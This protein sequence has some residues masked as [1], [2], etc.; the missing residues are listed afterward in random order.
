MLLIGLLGLAVNVASMK[1]LTHEST[2]SLNVRSAY[3]EVLSDAISSIGVI[4]GG[5]TIRL[6]GWLL[7]DPLLSAGIS[8]FIVWRTW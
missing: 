4:L 6:T 5:V 1:L 8:V 3:L 7:I 2:S